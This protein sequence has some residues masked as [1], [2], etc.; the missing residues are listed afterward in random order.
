MAANQTQLADAGAVD[1]KSGV[2]NSG[3]ADPLPSHGEKR[4][5][6][7]VIDSGGENG[8]WPFIDGFFIFS[9]GS[10]I[11]GRRGVQC[12]NSNEE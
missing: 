3:A 10:W 4:S 5:V 1:G 6:Q 7:H 12:S 2:V 8:N 9:N 11:V